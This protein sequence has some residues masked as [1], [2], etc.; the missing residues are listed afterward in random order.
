ME[1][2]VFTV[3][4]ALS[5]TSLNN[6]QHCKSSAKMHMNV[7]WFLSRELG[8]RSCVQNFDSEVVLPCA[9]LLFTADTIQTVSCMLPY[10]S[11]EVLISP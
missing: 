10:I 4:Y 1:T 7:C 5:C 3:R 11:T 6:Q 2:V 8:V 9:L